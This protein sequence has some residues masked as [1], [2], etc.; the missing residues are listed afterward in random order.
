MN[1]A[2]VAAIL[3]A[4]LASPLAAAGMAAADEPGG[5]KE[6]LDRAMRA[7]GYEPAESAEADPSVADGLLELA[8][9]HT[10]RAVRM[11][12]VEAMDVS[13]GG[14]SYKLNQ[15]FANVGELLKEAEAEVAAVLGST[16]GGAGGGIVICDLDFLAEPA[17]SA[18][19]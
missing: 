15:Q 16:T 2:E 12:L 13:L 10:L 14:N 7:L 18:S 9:W 11:A 5:L 19:W 8:T 3:A 1:R 6:P 17:G 4:E